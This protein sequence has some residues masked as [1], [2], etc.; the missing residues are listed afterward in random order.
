MNREIE[1]PGAPRT[2]EAP[3]RRRRRAVVEATKKPKAPK[4]Q[5]EN[6][7]D[8]PVVEP[9]V[10]KPR[11]PKKNPDRNNI[12]DLLDAESAERR[13]PRPAPRGQSDNAARSEEV[14]AQAKER[15]INLNQVLND[16][17]FVERMNRDVMNQ[18]LVIINDPNLLGENEYG[19]R[20]AIRIAELQIT[21]LEAQ[22]DRIQQAQNRG[23]LSPRDMVQGIND[24]E[25]NV[26]DLKKEIK[27]VSDA[28]KD[29]I[30]Q[31]QGSTPKSKT[32]KVEKPNPPKV[33]NESPSD[34][35]FKPAEINV[36]KLSPE[37]EKIVEDAFL[38]IRDPKNLQ[39]FGR[40][41]DEM[42]F[43]DNQGRMEAVRAYQDALQRIVEK[44]KA[45]PQ[46]NLQQEIEAAKLE[47]VKL[48]GDANRL[49]LSEGLNRDKREVGRAWGL[50]KNPGVGGEAEQVK[51][52]KEIAKKA[53][54]IG[55]REQILQN[56]DLFDQE[57]NKAVKRIERGLNFNPNATG[58]V[59]P[60]DADVAKK[61]KS[62]IDDAIKRRSG[63]LAEHM[64]DRYGS[65]KKPFEDMTKDKW[66]AMSSTDRQK[67]LEQAFGHSVIKGANGKLYNA[68]ATVRVENSGNA[69]VYVEF[70]EIDAN[71]RILRSVGTSG[72][73]VNV[74]SGYVKND[75]MFVRS[76]LDRGADI[77]TI[78]NQHSF[79]YL[80]NIGVTN[81]RIG[82]AVQDG[83]YVWA[84]VGFNNG[85]LPSARLASFQKALSF[86]E[87]F[88]GG[89][90][91]NSSAEYFRIK[92]M[93]DQTRAGRG[94]SHQE[95]IFAI[96]DPANDKIRREFVKH[97]FIRNAPL[98]A[99]EFSFAKNKVGGTAPRAGRAR[100]AP[101]GNA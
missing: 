62:Q 100:Q 20:Q 13:L 51:R 15:V 63:K 11:R 87:N 21:R 90:L 68:V 49:R 7:V 38:A 93:V 72:R 54:E 39:E 75:T 53:E 24:R 33:D 74:I 19:K 101:R 89:G 30:K 44:Y 50:I 92:S 94:F 43:M 61:I 6:V 18:R 66:N 46:I 83:Q 86:Y 27:E 70:N 32:P 85:N 80:K 88:G 48:N 37:N 98:P 14:R 9:K 77:Q 12:G 25:I 96:D 58:V 79:L 57:I 81:A 41:V 67:Y 45:N 8:K 34:L 59:K 60:L 17:T 29:V 26:S 52:A 76:K 56:Y 99:G 84:R 73:T 10:V 69:D 91:I 36:A 40:H 55:R 5:A 97:W 28:W 64:K 82:L 31:N 42:I 4:Q 78:Y 47:Y 65:A 22:L 16:E 95:W 23:D 35:A 2:G 71:G 3:A 1:Q